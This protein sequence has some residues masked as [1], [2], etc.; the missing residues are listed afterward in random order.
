MKKR[1]AVLDIDGTL[2][3]EPY[4]ADNL[5]SLKENPA[6]MLVAIALQSE[7]PVIISTARPENL[8]DVTEKWLN[9]HGL[10]PKQIYMRPMEKD[11]IPDQVVKQEHLQDIRKK[12][13]QPV[14]WADDHPG[15]VKMLQQNNVPVIHV[16]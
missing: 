3:A 8:R 2:T 1:P 7:R 10:K 9:K 16:N 11:G 15:V 6:M 4:V 12:Y 5:L 13:G 14:V